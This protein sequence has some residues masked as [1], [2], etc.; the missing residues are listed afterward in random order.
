MEDRKKHT[1]HVKGMTC[2]SCVRIVEESISKLDG[3]DFTSVNLATGKVHVLTDD[4][5]NFNNIREAIRKRGYDANEESPPENVLEK[6][7]RSARTNMIISI[8]LTVPL[9]I[10]MIISMIVLKIR[11]FELIEAVTAGFVL[12]YTGRGSIKGAWIAVS[13]FHTNMD[14]LVVI[15]AFASWLTAVGES[16]GYD[17]ISFGTISAMIISL[18]LS[19]RYIESR[20][21][22]RAWKEI[23][24]LLAFEEN[25]VVLIKDGE[26]KTVPLE[27]IK[28]GDT[29][30]LRTGERI[31]LDGVITKGSGYTNESLATG[32]PLPVY[33]KTG[34]YLLSGTILESGTVE[35]EVQK[36]GEDTFIKQMIKLVEDAQSSK[37]PIQALADR[38]TLVF[39]PTVFLTALSAASVWYIFYNNFVPF[40]ST[41]SSYIPWVNPDAGAFSTALFVFITTL[42][43]ACPCALGLA[44]PMALIAGTTAAATSGLIIKNGEA[45][46][47]ATDIDVMI[48]DKTGTITEGKPSVVETDL[49]NEALSVLA[50]LEKNSTHPL[51]KAVVDFAGEKLISHN[52]TA[53]KELPGR[54]IEGRLDG[55][56][57]RAGIP[58]NQDRYA[59]HYAKGY[60]VIEATHD[61]RSIGY[62][63]LSDQIKK[64]SRS[65]ILRLKNR[66][67]KTIMLTGDNSGAASFTAEAAGIDEF[68][69]EMKPEEKVN[70]IRQLQIQQ[71]RVAMAGDGINDAAALKSSELGIAIGS[72]ADITVESADIVIVKGELSKINEAIDISSLTFR[73]IKRNLFQAFFYN[74]IAIPLAVTGILHPAIAESAMLLS[75]MSVIFNSLRIKNKFKSGVKI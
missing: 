50:S 61:S 48:L 54:G 44:T 67:I 28:K 10:L 64:E 7:Y 51:A 62:I 23:K 29:V 70:F 34:D 22:Q 6:E 39:I 3:V 74:I 73:N 57:Y 42:V 75:S 30:L 4:R 15:G 43:I 47:S 52:F 60:T 53:I 9:M 45:I 14:T 58:I 49:D 69:A 35:L 2:A 8:V 37:V 36:T 40:L 38:I 27:S 24:A 46:Q 59:E 63:A 71:K 21:K 13:H 41:V 17:T 11:H 19:G 16:L 5:V 65:A 1:F 33:K 66:G 20:L 25:E 18:H 26:K 55:V 72:G 68:R 56:Q 12:F 31:S 32:E